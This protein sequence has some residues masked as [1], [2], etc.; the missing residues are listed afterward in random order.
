MSNKITNGSFESGPTGWT[1]TNVSS[2]FAPREDLERAGLG[3][4]RHS[5]SFALPDGLM[6]LPGT[7]EARRSLDGASLTASR[8]SGIG[9]RS[10]RVD[11][12]FPKRSR[13]G[14][15]EATGP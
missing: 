12:G 3:S 7:I 9:A 15:A 14:R 4:G 8:G 6:L 13:T 5:F 11:A 1:L 2:R 10:G